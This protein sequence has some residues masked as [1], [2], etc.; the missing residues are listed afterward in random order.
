MPS[1][2]LITA[3]AA[4][5]PRQA[6]HTLHDLPRN[7]SVHEPGTKGANGAWENIARTAEGPKASQKLHEDWRETATRLNTNE[8]R[9]ERYG[10]EDLRFGRQAYGIAGG[11]V[12]AG[13]VG[14]GALAGYGSHRAKRIRAGKL[15]AQLQPRRVRKLLEPS[16][17][18]VRQAHSAKGVHDISSMPRKLNREQRFAQWSSQMKV[19]EPMV[20]GGVTGGMLALAGGAQVGGNKMQ[21][22]SRQ[23]RAQLRRAPVAKSRGGA[24]FVRAAR[25]NFGTPKA[26]ATSLRTTAS[27]VR[28][29]PSHVATGAVLAAG[30]GAQAA[31]LE[32]RRTQPQRARADQASAGAVGGVAARGAWLGAGYSVR[33]KGHALERTRPGGMSRSKYQR[34]MRDHHRAAEVPQNTKPDKAH[35]PKFYRDYPIRLPAAKYKRVLGQMS[36]IR[37]G[38]MQAGLI[39]AGTIAGA[40]AVGHRQAGVSKALYQR[41]QRIS[42][43]RATE[44][45]AGGVLAAYGLSHSGMVGRAIGRGIK[46]S[47]ARNHQLAVDALVRAQAARGSIR[48]GMAPGEAA[49]RRVASVNAA[50]ERVPRYMRAEVAA[51]AGLLLT[52]NA[53]PVSR[54]HY[55]QVSMSVP[56]YGRSW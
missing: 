34:I 43:L 45:A 20:Y 35:A 56:G 44:L 22:A 11:S 4:Q 25:E 13:V 49:L 28:S 41:E 39:G 53:M 40:G 16:M 46:M 27:V 54:T 33:A 7:Y 23:R 36:G 17:P 52:S 15:D 5:I 19:A 47:S 6:Q 30:L 3:R 42:P 48:V 21:R 10:R 8:Q 31:P 24:A 12:A 51:A 18:F 50:I 38:V 29:N 1:P 2:R 55:R 9:R 14:G 26:A 32:R 37:G